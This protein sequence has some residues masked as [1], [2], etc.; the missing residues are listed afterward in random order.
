MSS[1]DNVFIF[2]G[3]LKERGLIKLLGVANKLC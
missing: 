2:F 1:V 3:L